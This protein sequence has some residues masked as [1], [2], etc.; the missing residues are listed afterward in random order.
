MSSFTGGV[1]DGLDD[2]NIVF[3][4]GGVLLFISM[5][6]LFPFVCSR[7]QKPRDNIDQTLVVLIDEKE[8]SS[9]NNYHLDIETSYDSV[10]MDM[11][12]ACGA[13]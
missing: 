8:T 3:Y 1:S 2:E 13:A 12:F 10:S 11:M 7:S 6:L 5:V 9:W 4:F